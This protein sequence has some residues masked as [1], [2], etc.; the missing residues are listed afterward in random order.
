MYFPTGY[1]CS[2]LG[3][4][5]NFGFSHGRIGKE[6]DSKKGSEDTHRSNGSSKSLET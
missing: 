5:Y 1:F 2:L 4:C 3:M 6:I